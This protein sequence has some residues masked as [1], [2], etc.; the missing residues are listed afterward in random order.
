LLSI[1]SLSLLWMSS[2]AFSSEAGSGAAYVPG[3]LCSN[4]DQAH[5][6][7]LGKHLRVLELW[8]SPFAVQDDTAPRGWTGYNI[9]LMD[10]IAALLGCT[11]EIIDIAYPAEGETWTQHAINT[12]RLGDLTMSFWY[13]TA[14]RIKDLAFIDGHIDVSPGLVARRELV[15]EEDPW[16]WNSM[17][18][19]ML[20]F[21]WE[22]W[23]CLLL[24]V[25][26]SGVADWLIERKRSEDARIGASLYE[27]AA[28]FLWGG[29]EYPLTTAS[30]I[31]Q[32]I[33]GFALL[34]V[35]STYTANL[36][37]FITLSQSPGLSAT[38]VD[39]AMVNGKALC[40]EEGGYNN[41]ITANFPR[42]RYELIT[43]ANT[44]GQRLIDKAGCEGVI[45]PKKLLRRVAHRSNVLQLGDCRDP[46]SSCCG[47][48][49]QQGQRVRGGRYQLCAPVV[50]IA[51]RS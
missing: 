40:M 19:F 5:S 9:E 2:V 6:A 36:A 35:V 13:K 1:R 32:I 8:W 10:E 14:E 26:G 45:A 43:E 21:K 41:R 29:F 30:K 22:L 24:M 31:F 37:A 17:T 18:S 46:L 44:A 23:G 34:I 25:L 16:S 4:G 48:D 15:D 42:M 11:Y 50:E 49:Q 20:P 12:A 38:S 27:Y 33:M 51:G 28:G 39:D 3:Q 47:V 7:L